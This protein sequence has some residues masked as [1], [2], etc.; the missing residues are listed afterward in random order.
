[1]KLIEGTAEAL[2]ISRMFFFN[3]DTSKKLLIQQSSN[4]I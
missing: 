1:L 3:T 2:V 4:V